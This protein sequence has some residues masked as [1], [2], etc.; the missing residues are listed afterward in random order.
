M[1]ELICRPL[2]DEVA[3][4]IIGITLVACIKGR[5]GGSDGVDCSLQ[6]II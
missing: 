4:R 3:R 2:R 1:R 6:V 5:G